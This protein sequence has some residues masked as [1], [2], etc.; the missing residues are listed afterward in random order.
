MS[1]MI[2]G[3]EYD[4]GRMTS[5]QIGGILYFVFCMRPFC[6]PRN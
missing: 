1:K 6:F 5:V 2:T 4:D 3:V